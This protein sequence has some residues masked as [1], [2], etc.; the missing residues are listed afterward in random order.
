MH[1]HHLFEICFIERKS[2]FTLK[3]KKKKYIKWIKGKYV[4]TC[5]KPAYWLWGS[6]DRMCAVTRINR[7]RMWVTVMRSREQTQQV[8]EE[9]DEKQTSDDNFDI[10]CPPPEITACHHP[11]FQQ[12]VTLKIIQ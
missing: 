7:G 5:E 1:F 10:G 8:I 4:L 12:F 6:P 9:A 2:F 3:K 11:L